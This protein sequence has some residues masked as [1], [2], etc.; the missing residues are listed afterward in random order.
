MPITPSVPVQAPAPDN[1]TRSMDELESASVLALLAIKSSSPASDTTDATPI[2]ETQSY[3]GT[4]DQS[5]SSPSSATQ[6]RCSD[7]S[8]EAHQETDQEM[9]VHEEVEEED[10]DEIVG[11]PSKPSILVPKRRD[12]RGA[13]NF[14]RRVNEE[15]RIRHFGW[16]MVKFKS[17]GHCWM[18][19]VHGAASSKKSARARASTFAPPRIRPARA[20]PCRRDAG[21]RVSLASNTDA[22]SRSVRLPPRYLP[23]ACG[24]P[25]DTAG[26]EDEGPEAGPMQDHAEGD[27]VICMHMYRLSAA[28]AM[29]SAWAGVNRRAQH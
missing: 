7:N 25:A 20:N 3:I 23:H 13:A 6:S 19:P 12:R 14:K 16:R 9:E 21:A 11:T 28:A 24:R 29:E 1:K 4:M 2:A 22:P 17:G 8:E 10:E 15:A 18:H 27:R 26:G 5:R